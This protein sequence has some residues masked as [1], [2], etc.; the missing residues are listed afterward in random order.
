MLLPLDCCFW[1]GVNMEERGGSFSL[2]SCCCCIIINLDCCAKYRYLS[3]GSSSDI[4][5]TVVPEPRSGREQVLI[6]CHWYVPY[7]LPVP[8]LLIQVLIEVCTWFRTVVV[9]EFGRSV[10]MLFY[11]RC[12]IYKNKK[13]GC[14]LSINIYINWGRRR[15]TRTNYQGTIHYTKKIKGQQYTYYVWSILVFTLVVV[16]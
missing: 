9:Y 5:C 7:L 14:Y 3:T 4:N 2:W 15:I 10:A 12:N 8:V 6:W 13:I 1:W 11:L 16:V